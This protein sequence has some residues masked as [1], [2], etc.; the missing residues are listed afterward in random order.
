MSLWGKIKGIFTVGQEKE[1]TVTPALRSLSPHKKRK[2]GHFVLMFLLIFLVLVIVSEITLAVINFFFW[3]SQSAGSFV[4]PIA[5]MPV[6]AGALTLIIIWL[7]NE[8]N[9]LANRFA[10]AFER[11][12][13]G[14]FGYQLDVPKN[15]QFKSL[16]ENFNKMSTELKS[17]QTL[18]DEFI[19][20]FSHEF[21]TPIASI[22]G[23]ANLLLEGGLTPEEERQ[24]LRI[25][26]DESAR[27][28]ALAENTLMLNRLENQQF[29]GEVHP[30]RLDLQLKECIILLE[31]EWAAKDISINSELEPVE[32]EG[33]ANLLQQVWLNLLSNAVKFTPQ[34]G[35]IGVNLKADGAFVEV[36]VSDTGIGMSREVASHV[37][38]KYYQ[39]DASH[40]T[41]GNGLGL[42]IVK[43]IVTLSGGRV[44]VESEEG[45]GSTFIVKLP[46]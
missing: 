2:T 46:M 1:K 8:N 9:K 4:V 19:H 27:L 33:N 25:I 17:I 23:F 21:K 18:K 42:A 31:H 10:D 13:H 36:R 3:D 24:Y 44:R 6:I 29:V 37:F 20:D 38:D 43:R 14:E 32:Y 22:N 40:S 41:R 15:G 26:S 16:F 12:S 39:G 11:L 28:S 34:H 5:I 30:Y 35:E 7:N 45:A